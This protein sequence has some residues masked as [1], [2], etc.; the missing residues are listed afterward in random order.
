MKGFPKQMILRVIY[1]NEFTETERQKMRHLF[2]VLTP[3]YHIIETKNVYIYM[4]GEGTPSQNGG[5]DWLF[6]IIK[7]FVYD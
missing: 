3:S 4:D 7:P 1:P 2:H 6:I 5:F